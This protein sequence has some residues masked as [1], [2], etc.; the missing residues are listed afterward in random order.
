MQSLFTGLNI[1]N[2]V[3]I[4]VNYAD[5]TLMKSVKCLVTLATTVAANHFL[6]C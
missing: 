3:V 1:K 2:N 5:N 4:N 6:R